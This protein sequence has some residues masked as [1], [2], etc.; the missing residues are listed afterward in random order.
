MLVSDCN[1]MQ[2]TISIVCKVAEHNQLVFNPGMSV[3]FH[4]VMPTLE[5]SIQERLGTVKLRSF[6]WKMF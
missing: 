3:V 6:I 4:N 1:K 5:I 2:S